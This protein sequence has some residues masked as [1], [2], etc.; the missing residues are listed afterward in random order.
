VAALQTQAQVNP[1][2]AHFQAFLAAVSVR[3]DFADL[4]PVGAIHVLPSTVLS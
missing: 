2:I 3:C 4:I 1:G